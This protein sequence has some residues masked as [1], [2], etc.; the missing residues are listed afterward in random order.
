MAHGETLLPDERSPSAIE[1]VPVARPALLACQS[2][3]RCRWAPTQPP[4][5][6]GCWVARW[7]TA[8]LLAYILVLRPWQLRWGATAAE[9]QDALPGDELLGHADLS[10][11]RALTVRAPTG[12]VWPWVAQQGQ[13]RGGFYSYDLL[14]NLV[15]CDIHSATQVI[16]ALQHLDVGDKIRLAPEVALEVAA[17]DPGRALILRGA[18]QMGRIAPPYDFTWAFVLRPEDGCTRFLVRERYAYKKRWAPLLVEPVAVVSFVMSQKMLR[19]IR[20]RAERQFAAGHDEGGR[21]GP[22]RPA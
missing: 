8:K 14:E 16:P 9:Q 18:V 17:V 11:T 4:M 15:G 19:G 3:R 2:A 13:G 1:G 20:A 6:A 21:P 22:A 10:A 5:R 7:G 12:V